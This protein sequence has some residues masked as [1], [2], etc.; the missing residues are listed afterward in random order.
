MRYVDE[1]PSAQPQ[2]RFDQR[3]LDTGRVVLR[4]RTIRERLKRRPIAPW[5][6]D[7][8]NIYAPMEIPELEDVE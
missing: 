6:T 3:D 5:L 7:P 1:T 4:P 8:G 2:F